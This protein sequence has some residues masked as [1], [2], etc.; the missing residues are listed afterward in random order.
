MN[1][2]ELRDQLGKLLKDGKLKMKYPDGYK[3]WKKKFDYIYKVTNGDLNQ[4]FDIMYGPGG[5]VKD[6][7]GSLY[8]N[9]EFKV[10]KGKPKP[11]RKKPPKA[12][13]KSGIFDG[14]K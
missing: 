13:T 2:T 8:R 6:Y 7:K 1:N 3:K 5:G 10:P 14:I 12:P 4:T 11:K 9:T